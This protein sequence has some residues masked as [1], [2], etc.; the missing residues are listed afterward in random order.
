MKGHQFNRRDFLKTSL[1]GSVA[2][3]AGLYPFTNPP[4]VSVVKI[5]NGNFKYAVE[6]A[7][8][9]LGGT[10]KVLEGKRKILL[11]PNLVAPY[12]HF[13]TKPEI[14]KAIAELFIDSGK[15]VCIAEG[16]ASAEGF[17]QKGSVEYRTRK[18]EILDPMQKY[19]FDKLG[20]TDLAKEL[21]IP[22]INL[23]SGELVDVEVPNGL[24]FNKITLHRSV[25][26]T[27]LLVSV[28][29]MKT[30]VLATVTLGMKNLIGVYPGSVYYSVRSFLHDKA[31][32]RGSEG[33]AYE[34]IDMVRA[35]KMG[36]TIIDASTAMEG[37][38]PAEGDLVKMDLIIAGTNPLATDFV[39]ANIMGFEIDEI[40]TF[41]WAVK[42]GMKPVGLDEIEVRG[43]RIDDV[44][45]KFKRPQIYPWN[46][47]NKVWGME[48]I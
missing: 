2:L 42:S 24:A 28:P 33:I 7:V 12:S 46:A 29:M 37:N 5:K 20:Y 13:T 43:E 31:F 47:I 23:H 18:P 36:L 32:E 40:P 48:E 35:S 17:N 21:D 3:A 1:A 16:S 44:K 15:E 9:L 14:V 27:D 4:I 19:I 25:A 38:G 6:T 22:L 8:D 26:E 10:G 45:R 11:K 39:A 34:I 30:H 41:N